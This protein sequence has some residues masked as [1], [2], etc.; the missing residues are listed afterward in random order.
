MPIVLGS[1]AAAM[2]VMLLVGW[3]FLIVQNMAFSREAARTTWLLVLGIVSFA[4]IITVLVMFIVFLTREIIEVR[5]QVTFIDSVTHEL[6]SPLASIKLALETLGRQQLSEEQERELREMMLDDVDRLNTFIDDVLQANR[7]SGKVRV[8]EK[9]D[10]R[11]LT[12]RCAMVVARRHHVSEDVFRLDI[13]KGAVLHTDAT[14]LET[15]VKNLMDNAVK[16]SNEPVQVDVRVRSVKNGRRMMIEVNDNGIGLQRKY[17]RRIFDRFYRVPNELVRKRRGM[18]LGLFVVNSLVRS[19][20][21]RLEAHSD[22]PG[23]GTSMR[24]LLPQQSAGAR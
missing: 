1:V 12:E 11:K 21:G 8:V 9:V 22:G 6:K 15:A 23:H 4:V 17:L 16:Y 10:L 5:R 20:G 13:P 18:G 14:A 7:A 19:L 24:I 3:I 2:G